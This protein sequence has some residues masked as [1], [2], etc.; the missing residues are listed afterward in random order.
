MFGIRSD[1][2]TMYGFPMVSMPQHHIVNKRRQPKARF[3]KEDDEKLSMLVDRYGTSNWDYI[4]SRM[5]GRTPR[6]CH[7]RWCFYL[8]PHINRKEWTPEEDALLLSKYAELGSRWV[9]I[10]KFFQGRPETQVKNR[11]NLLARRAAMEG[12]PF[13]IVTPAPRIEKLKKTKEAVAEVSK[14]AE[15]PNE[16]DTSAFDFLFKEDQGEFDIEYGTEPA[17]L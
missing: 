2:S 13:P 3:T 11:W 10:S 14:Q 6:M 9:V 15:I 16:V 4:A 17:F 1:M 7:D 8:D 5:D 12:R